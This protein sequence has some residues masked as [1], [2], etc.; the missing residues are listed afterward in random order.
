M[1]ENMPFSARDG[2]DTRHTDQRG[3]R[4]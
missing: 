3:F 2:D 1:I 4:P